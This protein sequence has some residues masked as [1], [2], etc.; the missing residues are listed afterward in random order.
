MI[1]W[2]FRSVVSYMK[3]GDNDGKKSSLFGMPLSNADSHQTSCALAL[4]HPTEQDPTDAL[5][6]RFSRYAQQRLWLIDIL[7][8]LREYGVF[9]FEIDVSVNESHQKSNKSPRSDQAKRSHPDV[10]CCFSILLVLSATFFFNWITR[11]SRTIFFRLYSRRHV[12][13]SSHAQT[14]KSSYNSNYK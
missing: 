7:I 1:R 6:F 9:Q 12:F 11:F 8:T 2:V 14:R 5:H 10:D 4:E 3:R 13:F